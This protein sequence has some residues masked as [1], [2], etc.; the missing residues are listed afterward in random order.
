MKKVLLV[1]PSS[2]GMYAKAKV[3]VAVPERPSLTLATL[4]SP[5]LQH[6]HCVQI[7][8]L[9]HVKN[10]KGALGHAMEDMQP[11]FV[12]LTCTTPLVAEVKRIT[13]LVKEYNPATI[14]VA[15]GPH[16]SAF[17]LETLIESCVDVICQGE[18]DYVL[19]S[20]VEGK[21]WS[22]I[23]GISYL[24]GGRSV[25][26]GA[27]ELIKDLNKLPMP[28]WHLFDLSKYRT[29]RLSCKK[30]PVG[31]METS[32]GCVFGCVYCNK[33]VFGRT[34]RVKTPQR[35]VD[36]M[37]HML[38]CGFAEIH[39]MDD[40]FTTDL[41]RAKSIC[42]LIIERGLKFPWALHNGIRVDRIDQEF[43]EKARAAGCY[44]VTLGV[45]TG[46]P[47]V[48]K[49]IHK[50]ITHDQ[51]I[52]AVKWAKEAGLETLTYFMLG[53]PGETEESM[54]RTI[55]FALKLDATYSKVSIL[56]PLPGTPL[57]EEFERKGYLKSK[58]WDLYNQHD[59]ALVYDHPNLSWDKIFKYYN[60][61]YRRYY[62][63]PAFIWR[64]F[65]KDA[66]S[67][68][69]LYDARDFLRVKW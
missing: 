40:G 7:L 44:E 47:E 22:I 10:P 61:F 3:K 59:P 54:K 9:D 34:F 4:A 45:E 8:D 38:S 55:D 50:G 48:M 18:G 12:G 1:S 13:A 25:N 56:L 19:L 37:E 49:Q 36:E 16:P 42:D 43:L 20:L 33:T 60:L 58:Q 52:Q 23:P 35:V 65:K 27:P 64:R 29:P 17:P 57:F 31:T 68:N 2:K 53:L 62:L 15:G 14:V 26:T 32:R 11:D 41:K 69:L 46:D 63:R 24:N 21:D 28:A 6:G 30:N 5:L 39:I 51:V 67:S 66:F